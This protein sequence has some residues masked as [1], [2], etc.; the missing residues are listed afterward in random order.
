MNL[1]ACNFEDGEKLAIRCLWKPFENA[2]TNYV[3]RTGSTNDDVMKL[4][5]IGSHVSSSWQDSGR[6]RRK[7][8][9][10]SIENSSSSLS[11]ISLAPWAK[12]ISN[13]PPFLGKSTIL[14][15]FASSSGNL[16]VSNS[17]VYLNQ[18][19]RLS[20]Q[21]WDMEHHMK[22]SSVFRMMCNNLISHLAYPVL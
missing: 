22:C 18:R 7:R 16:V 11:L 10:H 15:L 3:K 5:E 14:C 13:G 17:R 20:L 19:H 4:S 21:L 8:K 9:W 6:G 2:V 12:V 1:A